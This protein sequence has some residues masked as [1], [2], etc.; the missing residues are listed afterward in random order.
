M[1]LDSQTHEPLRGA[2]V[3]VPVVGDQPRVFTTGDDGHFSIA[4]KYEYGMIFLMGDYFPPS[5]KLT[6]KRDGYETATVELWKQH[7]N[8]VEVVLSPV[9]K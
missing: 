6:V 3:L 7:T 1:V 4:P 9:T 8:F 2:S 5:S